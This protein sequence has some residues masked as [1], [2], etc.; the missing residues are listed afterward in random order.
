MSIKSKCLL[1]S[2]I[3]LTSPTALADTNAPLPKRK[4]ISFLFNL[5]FS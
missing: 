4:L 3:T 2:K 5:L 1:E